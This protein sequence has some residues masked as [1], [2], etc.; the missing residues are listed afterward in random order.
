MMSFITL[1]NGGVRV[2]V[3]IKPGISRARD[4]R[5]VDI[6]DGKQA[7]EITVAAQPEGGKANKELCLQLAKALKIPRGDVVIKAGQTGRIKVVELLGVSA[8]MVMQLI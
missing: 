8:E 2:T 1:Y 4:L 7:L 3:K 6:G 5:V